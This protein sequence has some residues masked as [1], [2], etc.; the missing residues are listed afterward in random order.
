MRKHV[1]FRGQFVSAGELREYLQAADIFVT[2]Y[3]NEAQVSSGA[4]SYAMGAGAAVVST[5]YWHAQE[6]LADG[7]GHLFPFKDHGALT[8]TLLE[9]CGSPTEL[10]R[11]RKAA[12]AFTQP[13]EWP[14]IGDSYFDMIR[15]ALRPGEGAAAAA[16]T[17]SAVAAA[18]PEL[19]LDHLQRMTDDTGIVQHATYCVPAR[20]T[21]YCV[22]DNAR[23]LIRRSCRRRTR[24]GSRAA[25]CASS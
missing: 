23:A 20:R 15:D 7:R 16:R 13:M 19:N 25:R 3:L 9:L 5:P 22:D 24:E 11:V 10:H 18:L 21:G 6:L 12:F 1:A 4:L 17:E 8:R 14:R 2:P